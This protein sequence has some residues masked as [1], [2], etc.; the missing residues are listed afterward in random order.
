MLPRTET[1]DFLPLPIEVN[2]KAG[3]RLQNILKLEGRT[4]SD[5]LNS[6]D[7]EKIDALATAAL[8]MAA[9]NFP[10]I[11][12]STW[13]LLMDA[14]R[15]KARDFVT[16]V[17][18]T[19]R[20]HDAEQE[21]NYFEE[22]FDGYERL[23]KASLDDLSMVENLKTDAALAVCLAGN[24]FRSTKGADLRQVLSR[25]SGRPHECV[26]L[27]DPNPHDLWRV[28]RVEKV[29]DFFRDVVFAFGDDTETGLMSVEL[30]GDGEARNQLFG[31]LP[32][33]Q[34]H[35]LGLDRVPDNLE[36]LSLAALRARK[37]LDEE[38]H[39]LRD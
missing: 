13:M 22:L 31:I 15:E 18:H 39:W 7:G 20:P 5:G 6:S 34:R 29:S 38:E 9:L 1:S 35:F 10:L 25:V 19:P 3:T 32:G 36:Q 37:R 21:M 33:R 16:S 28:V 12:E 14:Q 26:Y 8:D 27:G 17:M 11:R 2:V 24:L 4:E 23:G 30:D